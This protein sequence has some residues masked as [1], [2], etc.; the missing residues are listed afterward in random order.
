MLGLD[1]TSQTT[2]NL[3]RTGQLV[4]NLAHVQMADAVD[5]LAGSTG[6]RVVPPHKQAKGY[7]SV[8]DKF[9]LAGV[10]AIPSDEVEPPRVRESPIQ[11]EAVVREVRPFDGP[12]SGVVAVEVQVVRTH[13]LP[14]LLVPGSEHHI[15]PDRWDPLI[16]KFTHFYGGGPNVR[17][18][19]LA[20]AWN[21]PRH[22]PVPCP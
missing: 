21:I 18:S 14:D 10:T 3:Q 20:Q 19:H 8:R 1:E 2:A 15:N 9:A 13:V 16:M 11:L 22:P 17:D 12:G 7:R 4:L 6:S 5:R